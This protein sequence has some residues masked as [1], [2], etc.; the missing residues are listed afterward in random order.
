V[1]KILFLVVQIFCFTAGFAQNPP[2]QANGI[3]IPARADLNVVWEA[4]NKF[5]HKVWSYQLLPNRFPDK[6]ICNVLALCSLTEKDL[7]EYRLNGMDFQSADGSRKLSL[8]F[9]SGDIH[10]Q[11]GPEWP[12]WSTNLVVGVPQENQLPKLTKDILRKLDIPYS[13]IT[14]WIDDHKMDFVEGGGVGLV[15]G[16]SFTNVTYRR[17]Y[18]RRTVDGMPIAR[19]FYGFNVGEQGKI[20]KLSITWPKLKRVKSYLTI[21]PEKVIECLRKGNAIRGPVSMND[22]DPDWPA[23]KSVTIKRAIPSY[24]IDHTQLYPFLYLDAVIEDEHGTV[25]VVIQCPIFDKTKP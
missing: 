22:F 4:T 16:I 19:E 12:A 14:G 21:S 8:A 25:E 10:Y 6:I 7:K 24:L 15:N 18:F 3:T 9:P 13:D 20:S 11:S 17:V 2:W 1:K 23:V 5:P